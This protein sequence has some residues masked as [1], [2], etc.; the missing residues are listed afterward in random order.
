MSICFYRYQSLNVI[1]V[2][3]FHLLSNSCWIFHK[4][5]SL[6]TSS[7]VDVV[8]TLKLYIILCNTISV[9]IFL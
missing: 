6:I 7:L 5:S 2:I 1:A 3:F 4:H 8:V 9:F